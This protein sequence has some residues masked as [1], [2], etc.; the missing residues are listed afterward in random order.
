DDSNKNDP[1]VDGDK[2]NQLEID[3]S[4]VIDAEIENVRIENSVNEPEIKREIQQDEIKY[5]TNQLQIDEDVVDLIDKEIQRDLE[6][7][8]EVDVENNLPVEIK[9]EEFEVSPINEDMLR[10]LTVELDVPM[11]FINNN[12]PI[13]SDEES[14]MGLRM[15]LRN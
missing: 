3:N 15:H 10:E 12:N 7:K 9:T 14:C 2:N 8:S 1:V 13:I 6:I 5:E 4:P 11:N